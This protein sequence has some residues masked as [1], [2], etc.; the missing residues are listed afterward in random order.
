MNQ[1]PQ[2]QRH[3]ACWGHRSSRAAQRRLLRSGAFCWRN[4]AVRFLLYF[5][6]ADAKRN[7]IYS[8]LSVVLGVLEIF[9][10]SQGIVGI[11]GVFSNKFLAMSKK[12]KLHASV[13]IP[14]VYS[15]VL[16]LQQLCA[17]WCLGHVDACPVLVMLQ[18]EH[19]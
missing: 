12:G 4:A 3:A 16:V 7:V 18:H 19:W 8:E 13:S 14:S 11:R 2:P 9:A 15:T 5:C 17:L 1:T 6:H 10:V